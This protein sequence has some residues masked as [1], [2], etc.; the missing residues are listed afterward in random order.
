MNDITSKVITRKKINV[1]K[2]A[3]KRF[4][5]GVHLQYD[6]GKPHFGKVIKEKLVNCGF[7]HNSG[8]S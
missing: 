2:V 8:V 1:D 6:N 3:K 4:K 7:I 5:K